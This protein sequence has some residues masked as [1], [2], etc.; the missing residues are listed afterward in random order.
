MYR[1]NRCIFAWSDPCQNQ[2]GEEEVKELTAHD[3]ASRVFGAMQGVIDSQRSRWGRLSN[4]ENAFEGWWK[5]EFLLAIDELL[6]T[7]DFP[8]AYCVRAERKPRTYGLCEDTRAADL[9]VVTWSTE[10][11]EID[12]TNPSR[13]WLQLKHRGTWMGSNPK[14]ELAAVWEDLQNWVKHVKW[15]PEEVVVA[16]L[17]LAADSRSEG[18]VLPKKWRD[19]LDRIHCKFPRYLPAYPVACQRPDHEGKDLTR[20]V[21]LE[22][23][24]IS[25][26]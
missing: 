21:H 16:C 23:F 11:Q 9:L 19:E 8:A 15:C 10:R 26:R 7:S 24:T 5:A 22:F 14:R 6:W 13:I 2:A 25:P 4:F 20:W 1:T 18:G 3:I 12:E 17:I